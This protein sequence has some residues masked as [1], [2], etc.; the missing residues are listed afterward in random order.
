MAGITTTALRTIIITDKAWACGW[1]NA[2]ARMLDA[3]R[4]PALHLRRQY[5]RSKHSVKLV[6]LL[7]EAAKQ[8]ILRR[9]KRRHMVFRDAAELPETSC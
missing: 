3:Q 8:E 4:K 5:K 2:S 1:M 7:L 6:S 9:G